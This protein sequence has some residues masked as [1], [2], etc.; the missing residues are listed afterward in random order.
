MILAD[1]AETS[2]LQDQMR[3]AAKLRG[4]VGNLTPRSQKETRDALKEAL[5]EKLDGKGL[6]AIYISGGQKNRSVGSRLK[7]LIWDLHGEA[8]G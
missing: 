4:E 6:Q 8:E 7:R 3:K 5:H 1:V 2:L